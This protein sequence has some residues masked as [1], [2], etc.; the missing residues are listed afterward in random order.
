MNFGRCKLSLGPG[1]AVGGKRRKKIGEG[2]ACEQALTLSPNGDLVHRPRGQKK[3]KI[4]EQS[5]PSGS[6]R[7]PVFAPPPLPALLT[8][9]PG[10]KPMCG[11]VSVLVGSCR[12]WK[13]G[14]GRRVGTG[15]ATVV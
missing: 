14:R 5:E 12:S 15:E 10:P 8:T 3:K 7:E 11:I 9:E 2:I 6:L 13:G 1:S 4:S